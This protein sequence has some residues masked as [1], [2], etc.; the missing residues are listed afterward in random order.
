MYLIRI[1]ENVR[2]RG[3]INCTTGRFERTPMGVMRLPQ[4]DNYL[5]LPHLFMRYSEMLG[6]KVLQY[7]RE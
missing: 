2:F 5:T 3:T 7:E 1:P 6:V 4:D